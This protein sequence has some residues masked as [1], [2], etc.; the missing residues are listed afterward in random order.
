MTFLLRKE[1]K[2]TFTCS[3]SHIFSSTCIDIHSI[4]RYEQKRKHKLKKVYVF[5]LTVFVLMMIAGPFP[6][7]FL[8]RPIGFGRRWYGILMGKI[9]ASLAVN[10]N[11]LDG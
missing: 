3:T 8:P 2:N 10:L 1:R 4:K 11:D 9:N 7:T 6:G 5:L